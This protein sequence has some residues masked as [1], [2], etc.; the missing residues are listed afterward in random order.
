MSSEGPLDS[1]YLEWL[2]TFIGPTRNRNPARSHWLLAEQLFRIPFIWTVPN[3]DNR[4]E[5][6]RDLRYEF[7][8]YE[9]SEAGQD[10]IDMDCSVLEVLIGLSRRAAFESNGD[11]F[12]WFWKIAEN[13]NLRSYTDEKYN[14]DTVEEISQI[15]ERVLDRNYARDGRGGLFPLKHAGRDQRKVELWYQ[16]SSY[17][18]ENGF[19]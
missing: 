9:A 8:D 11:Q 16:M 5:D 2:Y 13:V 1:R 10:W 6:A 18:L 19:G 15:I 14:I 4:I 3:D 17:L 12:D 7:L